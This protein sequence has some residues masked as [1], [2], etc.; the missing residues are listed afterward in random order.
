[1]FKLVGK[2]PNKC[3]LACSGGPDSMFALDFLIRGKKDVTILYMNHGTEHG[4]EAEAFVKSEAKRL[5]VKIEVGCVGS[6]EKE[7]NESSE[8]FWRRIR[9]DF[10]NK[11]NDAPIVMV[12]NLDDEV[13]NWIF[14]S[15]RGNGKLI[16]YRNGNVIRP[17][18]CISKKEILSWNERKGVP[19]VVDPG[20]FSD[21]YTRS[22][23]RQNL[24]PHA[25]FVNP[26]LH[27]TIRNKVLCLDFE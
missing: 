15:L 23:I 27:K 3:Y 16:P 12:H 6:A 8:Q 11:F 17:F 4:A 22:Y 10:L 20:N 9:Y 7:K 5:G 19:F 1:M 25:L 13:E 26:G 14:S 21:D 2:I 24:M 18:L